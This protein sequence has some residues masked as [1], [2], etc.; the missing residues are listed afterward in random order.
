MYKVSLH[1]H[2]QI[3]MCEHPLKMYS[4]ETISLKISDYKIFH[5]KLRKFNIKKSDNI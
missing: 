4:K 2:I 3:R 1:V 5:S